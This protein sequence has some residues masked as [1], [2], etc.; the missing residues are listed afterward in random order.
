MMPAK[1]VRESPLGRPTRI[2]P[3][4]WAGALLLAGGWATL[5]SVDSFWNPLAF[6]GLWTGAALVMWSLG[7]G[8]YPGV[9]RHFALALIS[10][11][12]W[13]WFELVNGRVQNWEYVTSFEYSTLAWAVLST[14]AFS[15]VVPALAAAAALARRFWPP[16][17]LAELRVRPNTQ[18]WLLLSGLAL[19]AALLLFPT[20]LYPFVWVAPLLFFDGLVVFAGGNS[21]ALDVIKGRRREAAA[22]AV[23]GLICGFLWEFWNFWAMPK[24]DYNIPLLGFGKV[25]EM[26]ILGYGGYIPFALSIAQLVKWLDLILSG[27]VWWPSPPG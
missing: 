19:Q 12:L 6:F 22:L 16:S 27:R 24:W 1:A 14:V 7:R 5:W 23:G 9:A 18:R 8:C 13:W 26:P 11:P 21:L 25:F 4:L 3:S 15:T 20:Q 17:P 2:A 10:V